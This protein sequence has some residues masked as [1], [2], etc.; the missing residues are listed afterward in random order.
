MGRSFQQC[1]HSSVVVRVLQASGCR[2]RRGGTRDGC[3]ELG[4]EFSP[5]RGAPYAGKY[6]HP[7]LDVTSGGDEGE[8]TW[9]VLSK[10]VRGWMIE[11]AQKKSQQPPS[12]FEEGAM[13]SGS[14]AGGRVLA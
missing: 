14:I 4:P 3:A 7:S 1:C 2:C 10:N 6:L 8:P 13:Y 9:I 12:F 11:T 5:W